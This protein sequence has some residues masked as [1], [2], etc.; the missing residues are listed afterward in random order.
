MHPYSWAKFAA[1][2]LLGLIALA[3]LFSGDGFEFVDF[4]ALLLLVMSSLLM[5]QSPAP[6]HFEEEPPSVSD[7]DEWRRTPRTLAGL[8]LTLLRDA[9]WSVFL[10]VLSYVLPIVVWDAAE[11]R[12]PVLMREYGRSLA[13]LA[14]AAVWLRAMVVGLRT[15]R[16]RLATSRVADEQR[17][18]DFD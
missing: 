4:P 8:T 2:A 5:T 10:I 7:R 17:S 15:A 11:R 18:P 3:I 13:T 16:Q 9:I 12:Y 6:P 1:G 14:I